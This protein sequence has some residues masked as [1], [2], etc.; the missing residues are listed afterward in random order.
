MRT[1]MHNLVT[2]AVAAGLAGATLAAPQE[3]Q[4]APPS[5][6]TIYRIFFDWGKAAVSQDSAATLDDVAALLMQRGSGPVSLV[7][8][9]D[10]S[11]PAGANR[12]SALHRAEAVRDY[13]VRRGVAATLLRVSSRG[14]DMPLIPTADGVREPQNRRVD[15]DFAPPPGR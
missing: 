12:Q 5:G 15:V 6:P 13:L 3:Q 2:F 9:S 4:A 14:E 8:H 1:M 10:R 11:G 7:G